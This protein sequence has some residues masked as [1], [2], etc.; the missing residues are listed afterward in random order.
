MMRTVTT[1]RLLLAALL[2]AGPA[3]AASPEPDGDTAEYEIVFT[4]QW[5]VA[6]HPLEYPRAGLLTGPHFS[7][8]IG[9]SHGPRYA[10]FAEGALPTRGL[11]RLSEEGKHSPLDA[12]IRAAVASGAAGALFESDPIRDMARPAVTT[13][14]VDSAHP[15]VSAVAMIAP[16]P[17]WFAGAAGVDLREAG[18]W[19]ES[20]EVVLLAYDAGSD[21]GT[22]YEAPD[23]DAD[24]K[25][26][27][28]RNGSPHFRRGEEAV[29]VGKLTLRR[30]QKAAS[31]REPR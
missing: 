15:L 12:E 19:V 2:A 21:D 28:A 30:V 23:R 17:D 26:P 18:R 20:K 29:P 9:A 14:R 10:L 1:R 3:A 13:V 6:T 5:T 7:G 8:L 24:P 11:E 22:T 16:S 25:H 4:G 31:V 27:T